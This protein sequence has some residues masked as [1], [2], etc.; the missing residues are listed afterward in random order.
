MI[1]SI[2]IPTKNRYT[3]L[4][5]LLDALCSF[6]SNN[7]EIVIQDNSDNN[8][9]ILNYLESNRDSRIKYFYCGD[10]LS[11]IGN[12]DLAVNH[13]TGEYICFIGDDDGVMPYIVDVVEWM[14]KTGIK[15]LRGFKPNYYWPDQKSNY[16]SNDTSGNLKIKNFDYSI[17]K[18]STKKALDFTL[19][20]GGTSIRMLPCLYHGIIQREVLS[21]IFEKCGTY[22]PGPSP[23]MANAI[24]LTKFI[25]EYTYVDFPVVISGKSTK[26][27]GGQ[28]VLHKH[29]ARIEDV[30]HLPKDTAKNWSKVIPKYW[31]GPT[32]WAESVLKAIENCNI[33]VVNQLNSSYLYTWLYLFNYRDREEIFKDFKF[34]VFTVNFFVNYITIFLNRVQFF[35]NNRFSSSIEKSK[36]INNIGDAIILIN[37]KVNENKLRLIIN[38]K[39]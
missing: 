21:N 18:I 30:V 2:I 35:L 9:E 25:D 16:L 28:G 38:I 32:I 20:K 29:V 10:R 31:T 17:K 14:K 4:L 5:P 6:E 37:K 19:K 23:D 11:V 7:F 36:N 27:T 34:N 33:E 24:A 39:G 12:S 15:A 1:L 8:K 13:T 3:T 26:S 22:F